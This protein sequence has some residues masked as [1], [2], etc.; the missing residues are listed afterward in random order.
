MAT[1]LK[2][3]PSLSQDVAVEEVV[4]GW[5]P[6]P[7]DGHPVIGPSPAA[8]NSYIA[9]MH[10][11][12]SLAPIVGEMVQ[13]NC[14]MGQSARNSRRSAHRETFSVSGGTEMFLEGLF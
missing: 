12:V 10:S 2:F 8:A 7:I 3:V 14:S 1:A 11:G 9:I 4:I 5:R 6:L 13:M